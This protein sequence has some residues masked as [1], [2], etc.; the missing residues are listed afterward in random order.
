MINNVF[1]EDLLARCRE[2]QFKGQ[3]ME[4]A[5]LPEIINKE[6]GYGNKH[7]QWIAETGLPHAKEVIQDY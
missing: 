7:D 4:M 5:L 1:N 2:P 3:H 6:E